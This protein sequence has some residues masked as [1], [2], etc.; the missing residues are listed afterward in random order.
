MSPCLSFIFVEMLFEI[1]T[2]SFAWQ[3]KT[4]PVITTYTDIRLIIISNIYNSL[5]NMAN[6]PSD[7]SLLQSGIGTE[8]GR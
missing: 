1:A 3:M 2:I 8:K 7:I 6:D 5:L 4:R